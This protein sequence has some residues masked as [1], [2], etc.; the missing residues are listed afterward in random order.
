VI[1]HILDTDTSI[2][3]IRSRSASILKRLRQCQVGSVGI[4]SITLAELQY[5]VAKSSDPGRNQVALLEFCAPLEILVFGPAA[6]DAYGRIRAALEKK[7]LP[8]GPLDTLIAAQ[9]LSLPATLVTCNEREFRR[10]E[11]LKVENWLS[12]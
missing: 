11:G 3:L 12:R 10:I 5:G 9:A 4:S 2:E 1:R 6:A 7:G 8:I